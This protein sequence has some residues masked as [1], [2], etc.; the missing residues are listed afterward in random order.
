M[1]KHYAVIFVCLLFS[2]SGN[3]SDCEEY[4]E[5][6]YSR[7]IFKQV[8]HNTRISGENISIRKAFQD[9]VNSET[10]IEPQNGFITLKLHLDKFGNFCNQE[11]FQIDE[12]YQQ[13][14][15]NNGQLI[16]NLEYISSNL[17][18]WMNDTETKTFYLLRLKIKDGKIE[19]IF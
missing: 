6:Y 15:F 17:A 16:K 4:S 14:E 1:K 5:P 19:E 3:V 10:E 9:V 7:S 18:G 13:T 11:S 12:D 8:P 2:C